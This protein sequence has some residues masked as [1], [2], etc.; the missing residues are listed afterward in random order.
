MSRFDALKEDDSDEENDLKPEYTAPRPSKLDWN[1]DE[2]PVKKG[3]GMSWADMSEDVPKK[4]TQPTI[5]L[6][7][8]QAKTAGTKLTFSQQEILKQKK[9]ERE[10]KKKERKVP[11]H[12]RCFF[13]NT[14][15]RTMSESKTD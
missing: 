10:K 3:K 14:C 12:Q 1:G 6:T 5:A 8:E 7:K 4:K 9:A 2:S 13:W 11:V 15:K